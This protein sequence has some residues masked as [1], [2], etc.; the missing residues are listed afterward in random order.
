WTNKR[1]TDA[2]AMAASGFREAASGWKRARRWRH[3]TLLFSPSRRKFLES[4][5]PLCD[6]ATCHA[7]IVSKRSIAHAVAN[8]H[9]G[10]RIGGAHVRS[11]AVLSASESA[12]AV[13]TARSPSAALGRP[14]DQAG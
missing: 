14:G 5:Y 1:G 8:T 11:V 13:G 2:W 12:L 9:F 3:R 10:V 6:N 4:C 7:G